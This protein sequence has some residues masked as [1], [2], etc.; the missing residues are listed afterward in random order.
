MVRINFKGSNIGEGSFDEIDIVDN[1]EQVAKRNERYIEDLKVNR[2][3]RTAIE[4]TYINEAEGA[5]RRGAA[6]QEKENKRQI[7]AARTIANQR[8]LNHYKLRLK[9]FNLLLV[10][11]LM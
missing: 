11:Q 10:D 5:L 1:S 4:S 8:I 2:D 7:D 6:S 9:R 3:A